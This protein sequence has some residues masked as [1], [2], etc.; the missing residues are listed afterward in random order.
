VFGAAEV[1]RRVPRGSVV[2]VMLPDSGSRYLSKMFSDEWM[3]DN[4]LLEEPSHL[5]SV[6]ELLHSRAPHKLIA[7]MRVEKVGD[8]ILRMKENGISQM[9][10]VE[11]DRVLG[12]INE[13]DLLKF[14][15]SGI[16]T[17]HSQIEPII[18]SDF[19]FV[20]EE[21]SLDTVS[22]I[23]TSQPHEAVMVLRNEI[24]SDIITKIDLIEFL[25]HR[26]QNGKQ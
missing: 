20:E 8:V 3:R 10:V 7:A 2:V 15:L 13:A 11:N 18:Q 6:K 17:A 4:A 9:P 19:P 14:M 22:H 25:L 5:G 16:G 23:F 21:A 1:A 26:S 24:P 12:L